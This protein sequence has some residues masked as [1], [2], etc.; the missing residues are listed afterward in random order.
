[1]V[2]ARGIALALA[3][4]LAP[5][6]FVGAPGR[7]DAERNERRDQAGEPADPLSEI[8]ERARS[9]ERAEALKIIEQF[10]KESP[11]SPLAARALALA[12]TLEPD[13][14]RAAA[15][16]ERIAA[17]Y[18]ATPEARDALLALARYHV[19]RGRFTDAIAS[20]ERLL[21]GRDLREPQVSE[22]RTWLLVA[23]LG[24]GESAASLRSLQREIGSAP[25]DGWAALALASAFVSSGYPEEAEPLFRQ[26]EEAEG[27]AA[28]RAPALFGAADAER[29]RRRGAAARDLYERI[30]RDHPQ[31]IEAAL[32]AKRLETVV[33][34]SAAIPAATVVRP[35][36]ET[37]RLSVSLGDFPNEPEA[38]RFVEDFT[39][40]REE[41]PIVVEETG[42]NGQPV[43]RVLIGS[44]ADSIPA[45][46]LI[47][48]L[49]EDGYT[50]IVVTP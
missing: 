38:A 40:R 46:D 43:F 47:R 31:S 8:V 2:R 22:A 17:D 9:G 32:A 14:E 13:A 33:A 30:V 49:A 44:F 41:K 6:G 39:A 21:D 26:A 24:A 16:W 50:G 15:R 3:L 48:D 12:A 42:A 1:V 27:G 34:D 23:R 25:W 5:A 7:A 11:A 37:A 19:A 18:S 10:L 28:L 35:L 36:P 4:V 45:L 20:V 29:S